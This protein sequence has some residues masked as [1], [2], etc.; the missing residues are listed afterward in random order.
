MMRIARN[1]SLNAIDKKGFKEA[2]KNQDLEKAVHIVDKAHENSA[3]EL[4]D[5][6]THMKSLDARYAR[7]I[8]LTFFEGY[9]HQ[10]A[11]ELLEI[12]LGTLKSRI[13]IGLKE[14][15]RIY[16]YKGS[17]IVGYI[18]IISFYQGL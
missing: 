4:M 14:L 5:I 2:Q 6:K 12:P 17:A 1:L 16:E 11:S 15:K 8:E 3:T 10:D 9:T 18:Y 7:V 13:R